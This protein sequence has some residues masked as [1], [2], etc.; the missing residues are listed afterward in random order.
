[1]GGAMHKNSRKL[2]LYT[3]GHWRL[4]PPPPPTHTHTHTLHPLPTCPSVPVTLTTV[5]VKSP[6]L[7]QVF[8]TPAP[9]E[10][11]LEWRG[12]R[13]QMS[14]RIKMALPGRGRGT[15]RLLERNLVSVRKRGKMSAPHT[16]CRAPID[17]ARPPLLLNFLQIVKKKCSKSYVCWSIIPD[18]AICWG[19]ITAKFRQWHSSHFK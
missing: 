13:R 16:Y 5:A 18:T 15:L 4:H 2:H 17:Q 9:G 3:G 6:L 8:S 14:D 11:Q 10:H 1:M 7:W 19:N 12:R